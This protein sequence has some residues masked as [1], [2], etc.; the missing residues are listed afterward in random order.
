MQA[1][2]LRECMLTAVGIV[3]GLWVLLMTWDGIAHINLPEVGV[4]FLG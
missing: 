1:R 2:S 4:V 3:L